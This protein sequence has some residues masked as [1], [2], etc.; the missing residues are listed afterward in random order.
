MPPPTGDNNVI[1]TVTLEDQ[2]RAAGAGVIKTF[3]RMEA[4]AKRAEAAI[5][6][7]NRAALGSESRPG[8]APRI[9]A[10]GGNTQK[11]NTAF[12][13]LESRITTL[14]AA[15]TRATERLNRM[16][17]QPVHAVAS[18]RTAASRS[19]AQASRARRGMTA[20][21][22]DA[23]SAFG[24]TRARAG[25]RPASEVEK[26]VEREYG[27]VFRSLEQVGSA[28]EQARNS[29]LKMREI[30]DRANDEAERARMDRHVMGGPETRREV[31]AHMARAKSTT[32]EIDRE[33]EGYVN[34]LLGMAETDHRARKA[35]E[36]AEESDRR[37]TVMGQRREA[38]AN[39]PSVRLA[40]SAAEFRLQGYALAHISNFVRNP[41]LENAFR[42]M[43]GIQ[44]LRAL[45][46]RRRE[47]RQAERAR[48]E[49]Q[50]ASAGGVGVGRMERMSAA[51]QRFAESLRR[52]L[53]YERPLIEGSGQVR[54]RFEQ[55]A[56]AAG[57]LSQL[58]S[59]A[60]NA[61][62]RVRLGRGGPGQAA[63]PVARGLASLS[64]F[65]GGSPGATPA[66]GGGLGQ[67]FLGL[68]TSP[69]GGGGGAGG[70]QG[71][72]GGG[73]TGAIGGAF[74]GFMGAASAAIP[75]VAG[76]TLA[77]GTLLGVVFKV[78][79]AIGSALVSAFETVLSV[80]TALINGIMRAVEAIASVI[81]SIVSTVVG[82]L[83]QIAAAAQTVITTALGIAG[84]FAAAFAVVVAK[85]TEAAESTDSLKRGLAA[86]MGNAAAAADEVVRLSEAAKGPGL[87]FVEALQG[88]VRLQAAGLAAR[89][90]RD[91]MIEFGNAVAL[92]GGGKENLQNVT[93]IL[94]RMASMVHVTGRDINALRRQ[95]PLIGRLMRE[96]YGTSDTRELTAMGIDPKKFVADIT[97]AMSHLPRMTASIKNALE[98]LT[99]SW[100]RV[101]A[102][103]GE[104]FATFL[105]PIINGIA[106]ML[107]RLVNAGVFAQIADMVSGI[108][109]NVDWLEVIRRGIAAIVA[110]LFTV[111]DA[112]EIVRTAVVKTWGDIVNVIHAGSDLIMTAWSAMLE[113]WRLAG[114]AIRDEWKA[115][116]DFAGSLFKY[117]IDGFMTV[118]K[119]VIE[120]AKWMGAKIGEGM[121]A[122]GEA[123]AKSQSDMTAKW[124]ALSD[125]S[126]KTWETVFGHTAAT[127][128]QVQGVQT[129]IHRLQQAQTMGNTVPQAILDRV[130]FTVRE[131]RASGSTMSAADEREWRQR[132]TKGYMDANPDLVNSDVGNQAIVRNAA[133]EAASKAGVSQQDL[134]SHGLKFDENGRLVSSNTEAITALTSILGE[135][136]KPGTQGALPAAMSMVEPK[137]AAF[138]NAIGTATRD[139]ADAWKNV[140]ADLYNA[141][142]ARYNNAYSIMT[143][144]NPA[145]NPPQLGPDN[146][147]GEAQPDD[148][149]M[150]EV[151]RNTERIARNTDRLRDLSGFTL[152]GGSRA[153]VGVTPVE[154][155]MAALER[156]MRSPD[157]VDAVTGMSAVASERDLTPTIRLA[158]PPRDP[159]DDYILSIIEEYNEQLMPRLMR[160]F[161]GLAAGT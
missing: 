153:E 96:V 147:Q 73:I 36:K 23:M 136:Q 24:Q 61:A 68:L 17:L 46:A 35:R 87:G 107:D 125:Q 26:S 19:V 133:V 159:L 149:D 50:G 142:A 155:R 34:S 129:A 99:D 77:L 148:G 2:T 122:A 108:L 47:E 82:L 161:S 64:S 105:V 143:G 52:A 132:L 31:A 131:A 38:A 28:A 121:E 25:L 140:P 21:E 1:T 76:F 60:A 3:D 124:S 66:S 151:A 44:A 111:P 41:G 22:A 91:A 118:G 48:A 56:T 14:G 119:V 128:Q 126:R 156:A 51:G 130:E 110:G 9:E 103:F 33:V 98:N 5:R 29:W 86:I 157:R 42:A 55:S 100:T 7:L 97:E 71:G 150:E 27:H 89:A 4:S 106:Q 114:P 154:I 70:G 79:T 10:L 134:E 84:A 88:S 145:G 16:A 63:N 75:V 83:G 12:N 85:T 81:S 58:L 139:A 54:M 123:L 144:E 141:W 13:R 116:G 11:L 69:F 45:G 57:R 104:A 120:V 109:S 117:L 72:A 101:L 146:F 6:A 32:P 113:F 115:I 67:S 152:G 49:E 15:V 39:L 62:G 53:S 74:R 138:Q 18:S 102:Q 30:N 158:L 95:V 137:W 59:R 80:I 92:V 20:A 112:W 127:P 160:A 40:R 8:T 94:A 93:A 78:A 135:M 65:F 90:A 37:R 43:G